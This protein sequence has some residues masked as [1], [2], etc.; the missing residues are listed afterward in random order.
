MAQNSQQSN[1]SVAIKPT[2]EEIEDTSKQAFERFK[3]K[4]GPNDLVTFS[5]HSLMAF[6]NVDVEWVQGLGDR[7]ILVK[8]VENVAVIHC[9]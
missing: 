3:A 6:P 9:H 5:K 1:E 4:V 7:A 2:V 8:S